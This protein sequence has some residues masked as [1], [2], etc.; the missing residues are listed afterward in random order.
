[1]IFSPVCNYVAI[2]DRDTPSG[3]C[4]VSHSILIQSSRFLAY[5]HLLD[6]AVQYI[7][8]GVGETLFQIF[9]EREILA[10]LPG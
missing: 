4:D 3:M 7:P 2:F 6:D 5:F 1:M 8:L 10:V 9:D